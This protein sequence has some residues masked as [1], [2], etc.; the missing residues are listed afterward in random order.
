VK[1][2]LPRKNCRHWLSLW[3][4]SPNNDCYRTTPI[5]AATAWRD[6]IRTRST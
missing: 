6:F 1:K 2:C 3:Q 4:T 5:D